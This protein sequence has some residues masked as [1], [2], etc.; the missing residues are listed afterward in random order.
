MRA[1]TLAVTC[2]AACLAAAAPA[3]AA[4]QPVVV[5][6][7][8]ATLYATPATVEFTLTKTFKESDLKTSSEKCAAFVIQAQESLRGGDVQPLEVQTVPGTISQTD[9]KTVCGG[10]VARFAMT[11]F[12]AAATGPVGFATLYDKISAMTTALGAALKAPKFQ[13]AES[14]T[15]ATQAVNKATENAYAAAESL[16]FALKS[17]IYSVQEAEITELTWSDAPVEAPGEVP[18]LSCTA[19]VRVTYQLAPQ[20]AGAL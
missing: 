19:K 12:N 18:Q 1:M 9:Q 4:E 20:T 3:Y 11:P 14:D 7:G 15:A 6:S 8:T 5:N 2:L 17:A 16:A 10:V 13:P